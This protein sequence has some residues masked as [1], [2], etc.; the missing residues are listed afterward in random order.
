M[1]LPPSVLKANGLKGAISMQS[2]ANSQKAI[3]LIAKQGFSS[4]LASF[5]QQILVHD[6]DSRVSAIN[7]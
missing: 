6:P 7:V 5:I 1:T 4:L 3:A 2:R